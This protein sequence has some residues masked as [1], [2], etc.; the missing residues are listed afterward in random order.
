MYDIIYVV[1]MGQVNKMELMGAISVWYGY[2][3]DHQKSCC[4]M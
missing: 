3:E 1:A 2:V 4:L